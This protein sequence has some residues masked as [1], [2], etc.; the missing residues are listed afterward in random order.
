RI[1]PPPP[2]RRI[3]FVVGELR[4]CE[5]FAPGL[6]RG[7]TLTS[8][9]GHEKRNGERWIAVKQNERSPVGGVAYCNADE[10]ADAHIDCHPHAVY[11]AA[12]DYPFAIEFDLPDAAVGTA[13]A[14]GETDGQ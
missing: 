2:R 10:F 4:K 13:V 11:G 7:G 14:C 1:A 3:A 5:D 6:A 12:Q 8:V 9:L